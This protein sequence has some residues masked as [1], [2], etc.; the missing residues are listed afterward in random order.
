LNAGAGNGLDIGMAK[1]KEQKGKEG[2]E[3]AVHGRH[4]SCG[5]C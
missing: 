1:G 2:E 4:G 3:R 5:V